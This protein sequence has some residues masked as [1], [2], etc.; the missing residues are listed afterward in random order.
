MRIH[1][2]HIVVRRTLVVPKSYLLLKFTIFCIGEGSPIDNPMAQITVKSYRNVSN[3]CTS[4]RNDG[5]F[6]VDMLI[7][8]IVRLNCQKEQACHSSMQNEIS[9]KTLP[10]VTK[11]GRL[12]K[13]V[14]HV[15]KIKAIA[16]SN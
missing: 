5:G 7:E 8:T 12:T 16:L 1:C 11:R 15:V 10:T 13:N 14:C 3:S 2:Y 9:A 6:L 4:Q